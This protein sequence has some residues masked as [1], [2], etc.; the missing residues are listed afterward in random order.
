MHDRQNLLVYE[1]IVMLLATPYLHLCS[2][3]SAGHKKYSNYSTL[4]VQFTWNAVLHGAPAVA[5]ALELSQALPS[6]MKYM[7]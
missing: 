6:S 5:L 3:F 2:A 4:A 1:V 7:G